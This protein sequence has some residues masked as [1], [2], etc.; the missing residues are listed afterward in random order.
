[1]LL[2]TGAT[3]RLLVHGFYLCHHQSK[4]SAERESALASD[5]ECSGA[6]NLEQSDAKIQAEFNILG[7]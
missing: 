6:A 5:F 4:S 2:H 7:D 3:R 1:V